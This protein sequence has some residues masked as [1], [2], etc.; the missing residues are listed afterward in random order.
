LKI[1]VQPI[2]ALQS[3]VR[4]IATIRNLLPEWSPLRTGFR[5]EADK[6]GSGPSTKANPQT[7]WF[8]EPAKLNERVKGIWQ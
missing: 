8:N 5:P 7:G 4:L 6:A 3:V 1:V 2:P